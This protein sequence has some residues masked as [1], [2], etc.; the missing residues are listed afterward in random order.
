LFLGIP[1]ES[2][3]RSRFGAN[4]IRSMTS[5]L[6]DRAGIRYQ[7]S[8]RISIRR[9]PYEAVCATGDKVVLKGPA[10]DLLDPELPLITSKSLTTG[11]VA[12]LHHIDPLPT[13]AGVLY[14]TSALDELKRS[15]DGM[16]F[17]AAG[18]SSTIGVTTIYTPNARKALVSARDGVTGQN[19]L[20]ESL[21]SPETRTVTVKHRQAPERHSVKVSV[22]W[23]NP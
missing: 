6:S 16:S 1:P 14:S 7:E 10:I 15:G 11:E 22:R 3:A 18:P 23:R 19:Q 9:G 4:V 20:V 5:Y 13:E 12:F 8:D 21:W 2:L 17:E